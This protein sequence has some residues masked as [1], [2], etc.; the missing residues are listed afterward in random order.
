[1]K[2]VYT[3]QNITHTWKQNKTFVWELL[4]IELLSC[5]H[6]FGAFQ[7][8]DCYKGFAQEK[9]EQ[10]SMQKLLHFIV[11]KVLN[12]I[13]RYNQLVEKIWLVFNILP[14]QIILQR[15]FFRSAPFFGQNR[16]QAFTFSKKKS[17]LVGISLKIK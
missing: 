9:A 11:K 16:G 7:L 1:M 4:R 13:L 15:R 17:H 5:S 2:V 12:N 10:I 6:A 8:Y 3:Q 14:T